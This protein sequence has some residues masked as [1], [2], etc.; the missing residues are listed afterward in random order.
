M[1]LLKNDKKEGAWRAAQPLVYT[2]G[3]LLIS[4]LITFYLVLRFTRPIANLSNAA[5]R[6]AEGDL[7]VRVPDDTRS[8]EMGQLSQRFNEMTARA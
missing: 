4:T 2:L 6:V 1:V 5:R 3:I 8:D 7:R